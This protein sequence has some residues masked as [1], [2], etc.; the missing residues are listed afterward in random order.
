M[1]ISHTVAVCCVA[2]AAS[3]ATAAGYLQGYCRDDLGRGIYE[4]NVYV[5]QDGG[6]WYGYCSTDPSGF[7][8]ILG[9]QNGQT[10]TACA[11]DPFHFRSSIVTGIVGQGTGVV[12]HDLP[13]H[14]NY[15]VRDDIWEEVAHREFG[16]TFLASGYNI[17]KVTIRNAGPSKSFSV[18][19]HEGGPGGAQLGPTRTCECGGLGRG[20]ASWNAGEV[21]TIPGKTY[22]VKVEPTD[23]SVWNSCIDSGGATYTDGMM[24]YDGVAQPDKDMALHI[25]SDDD[26]YITTVNARYRFTGFFNTEFGQTFVANTQ[27]VMTASAVVGGS[28]RIVMEFSVL[29]GP[30]GSQIGPSKLVEAWGNDARGCCACWAPGEV[31]VVPGET[32]YLRVRQASGEGVYVYVASST[33]DGGSLYV[34]GTEYAGLDLNTRIMGRLPD[35]P[36]LGM[37]DVHAEDI[38][39]TSA[40]IAWTTAAPAMTQVRYWA[41]GDEAS[42]VHTT[43]DETLTYDHSVVLSGLTHNTVYH[44]VAKSYAP[45]YEYAVSEEKTFTTAFDVGTI[46]GHVVDENWADLAGADVVTVPGG[47]SAQTGP[48]GTYAITDADPGV[49]DVVVSKTGYAKQ[50]LSGVQVAAFAATAADSLVYGMPGGELLTNPGFETGDFT[51]WHYAGTGQ[52]FSGTL[53]GGIT[54]YDGVYAYAASVQ[55]GAAGFGGYYQRVPAT[56]GLT[57]TFTAWSCP[58]WEYGTYTGTKNRIGIDP[59]GGTDKNSPDIVWSPYDYIYQEGTVEWDQLTVSA[60][61]AASY[62]T[63]FITYNQSYQF[64][65]MS[66]WHINC[67]DACSLTTAGSLYT[68]PVG[69]LRTGWNLM[70]IPVVPN[71]PDVPSALRSLSGAGNG[72]DNA[73]YRYDRLTGYEIFPGAFDSLECGRGY[74][75]Y[76]DA[77]SATCT[78]EGTPRPD[79][80]IPLSDGWNM[81]GAPWDQ[82]VEWASCEVT[83]GVSTKSIAQA[84]E[85]GWIQAAIFFYDGAYHTVAPSEGEDDSLRPWYGYWMLTNVPG[86]TLSVPQP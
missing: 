46:T 47:F 28:G 63:V 30:G 68:S 80:D 8:S 6:G 22:Y 29:D 45:G 77:M 36:S 66:E 12:Y 65:G 57:Y 51:G 50:T 32:Y 14:M 62:V 1:R 53:R 7:F 13:L 55:S 75:L 60:E 72:L 71:E 3:W 38:D 33:Y 49:Y 2:L 19:V 82:P 58:Y 69:W 4:V 26:G 17:I 34:N 70:S 64:G 81:F 27:D 23:G 84:E 18:S 78:V 31:P 67:Y 52:V 9:L 16:Q 40:V 37:A 76:L 48:D 79:G 54:P 59:T 83:D 56:P 74:W 41:D 5:N 21:P 15:T 11:H 44:Y 61:A 42:A 43:L 39:N 25:D 35:M 85:A 20:T 86:L 73:L 24:F 10:Y